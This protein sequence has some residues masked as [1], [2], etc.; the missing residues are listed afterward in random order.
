M[1]DENRTSGISF[2]ATNIHIDRSQI[3]EVI[4]QNFQGIFSSDAQKGIVH[5]IGNLE[6]LSKLLSENESESNAVSSEISKIKE[7]LGK[8][9]GESKVR[10]AKWIKERIYK[11]LEPVMVA[12]MTIFPA[13]QG[14]QM[15]TSNVLEASNNVIE[16]VENAQIF[17]QE[18]KQLTG[19]SVEGEILPESAKILANGEQYIAYVSELAKL[20]QEASE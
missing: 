1:I 12:L 20:L 3:A 16:I 4:N 2:N 14:L 18:V 6:K 15:T 13:S 5:S 7:E 8:N 9:P 19:A 17:I 11:L 10:D